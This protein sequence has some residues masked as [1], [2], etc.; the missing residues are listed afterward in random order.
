MPDKSLFVSTSILIA[1]SVVLVYSLSAYTVLLFGYSEFHFLIR[2]MIFG[3][4]SIV[5][6]WGLRSLSAD[7]SSSL[8]CLFFLPF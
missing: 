2:Q 1:I 8:P 5:V 4:L 3:I 7:L 6:M